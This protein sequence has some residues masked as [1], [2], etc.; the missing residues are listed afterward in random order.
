MHCFLKFICE[1]K[2][3]G[4]KIFQVLF[5]FVNYAI[6]LRFFLFFCFEMISIF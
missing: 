1:Y 6:Q 2:F 4:F 5:Y 3:K